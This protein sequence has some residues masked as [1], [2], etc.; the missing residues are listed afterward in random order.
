MAFLLLLMIMLLFK[1][2][3]FH[4]KPSATAAGAIVMAIGIFEYDLFHHYFITSFT[5]YKW[6]VWF[7]IIAW[8]VISGSFLK[9]VFN[10]TFKLLHRQNEIQSFA[11]GTWIASTSVCSTIMFN[12]IPEIRVIPEI[13]ISV[14]GVL[15][16]IFCILCIKNFMKLL[17]TDSYKQT[18]GII[19]LSTVSTQS[20][21]IGLSTIFGTTNNLKMI[22]QG[23]FYL[24]ILFY[25]V[26]LSIIVKRYLATYKIMDIKQ[27]WYNTNCVIHG[28]MSITGLAGITSGIIGGKIIIAI[29]FWVLVCFFLVESI[30]IYRAVM[31]AKYLGFRKGLFQ[32]HVSQWTRNFTFGMFLAFTIKLPVHFLSTS[33]LVIHKALVKY[34]V[35]VVILLLMIEIILYIKDNFTLKYLCLRNQNSHT[36]NHFLEGR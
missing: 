9:S 10:H 21:V 35:V 1:Y 15:W 18:H 7:L 36:E 30:E 33:L 32:Y 24:G 2:F 29:W 16:A 8:M 4:R 28:A 12:R 11:I 22:N 31:R 14:N 20:I 27:D 19:L 34:G 17:K 3:F 13:V 5:E 25:F 26:S 23:F 6:F